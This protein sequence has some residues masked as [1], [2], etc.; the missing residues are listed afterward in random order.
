MSVRYRCAGCGN[1]TRFD[2]VT[3][4]RTRE[5]HHFTVGGALEIEDE[6]VLESRVEA[7]TCRWCGASG[8]TI[9]EIAL[10]DAPADGE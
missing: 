1:L 3:T 6:E 4:R 8:A 7:V 2:V 10:E 9:E 5:F